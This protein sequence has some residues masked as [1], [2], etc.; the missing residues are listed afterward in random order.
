[1]L[2]RACLSPSTTA[3][4]SRA[5]APGWP[6]RHGD[7]QRKKRSTQRRISS[8]F[9][10]FP[11]AK[12]ERGGCGGREAGNLPE[13]LSYKQAAK[14]AGPKRP[15][16]RGPAGARLSRSHRESRGHAAGA[17]A[18]RSRNRAYRTLPPRRPMNGPH[19]RPAILIV[20]SVLPRN[21]GAPAGSPSGR[22]AACTRRPVCAS[23]HAGA[24]SGHP[25]KGLTLPAAGTP[26][27]ELPSRGT[28][29]GVWSTLPSR[30]GQGGTGAGGA[31]PSPPITTASKGRGAV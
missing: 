19:S 26:A 5:P 12:Q 2:P 29:D 9:H 7:G 3:G 15:V 14:R 8:I 21:G 17:D 18:G 27:E 10:S 25:A 31:L 11:H 13:T 22:P 1:M 4:Q 6:Q 28:R 20:P 23:A 24:H 30:A 16:P